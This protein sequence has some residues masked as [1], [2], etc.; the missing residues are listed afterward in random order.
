MTVHDSRWHARAK[1]G[2]ASLDWDTWGHT[3]SPPPTATT[4]ET[5][6][7]HHSNHFSPRCPP[8]CHLPI[9]PS[10]PLETLGTAAGR[11]DIH[12]TTMGES[13]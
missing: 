1:G 12:S 4:N 8:P 3:E 2:G 11:Q 10:N 5:Q 13:R 6:R 9:Q 7:Y